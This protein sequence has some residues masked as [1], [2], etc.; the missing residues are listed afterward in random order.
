MKRTLNRL[1][2]ES[3]DYIFGNEFVDEC[4][5][6]NE[7]SGEVVEDAAYELSAKYRAH[8]EK[9]LISNIFTQ[10]RKL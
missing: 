9:K 5:D 1:S 7:R 3:P 4:E 10:R 6:L 8:S 2:I